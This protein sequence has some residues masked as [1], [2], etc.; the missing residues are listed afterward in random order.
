MVRGIAVPNHSRI[1]TGDSS[2][3]L[4]IC[5]YCGSERK[6]ANSWKT[7]ERTCRSNLNRN[8]KN[9]MTGKKGHNQYTKA[10]SLSLPKPEVSNE[11][12]SKIIE[13]RHNNGNP[14]FSEK[15]KSNLSLAASKRLKKNSKYSKNFLYND[16]ILESTY[17]L[18]LAKILDFLNINWIKVRTG[19]IWNDSDKIRRYVPDF[20]IPSKDLFLDP[21]NDFL[22]QKDNLKIKSAMELNNINVI[23]LSNDQINK[24]YIKILL[25]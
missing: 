11:T 24:D 20:Y 23:V 22:I 10:L 6:N 9:G 12:K 7:H 8:Y 21:K 16:C 17:E 15:A 4:F 1:Q 3:E 5:R 18:R 13:S 2:M 25:G 19:Y 14:W